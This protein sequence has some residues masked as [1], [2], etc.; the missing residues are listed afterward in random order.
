MRHSKDMAILIGGHAAQAFIL[1]ATTRIMTALLS[2]QE[3]GRFAII[4]TIIALILALSISSV[5]TYIQRRIIEWK[6]AGTVRFYI[7]RYIEFLFGMA[8][9]AAGLIVFLKHQAGIAVD[10]SDAWI[11]VIVVGLVF[12]SNVNLGYIVNLNIFKKRLWF[13]VCSNFTLLVG[14]LI[15][16]VLVSVFAPRAEY[17]I[18]GQIIGQ[19]ILGVIGAALFYRIVPPLKSGNTAGLLHP[20]FLSDV[21]RFVWPLS[22][23][24]M[25]IW[26]Q[27]QSYR[28]VMEYMHGMSVV[29]FFT[30]GFNLGSRLVEKV[31]NLLLNFYDPIFF[32]NIADSDRSQRVRVWNSF[33]GFFI[34]AMALFSI[35]VCFSGHF[36]ARIFFAPG[37]RPISA[38]VIFWGGAVMFILNIVAAY[39][40][41]GIADLKMTGLIAPYTLGACVTLAGVFIFSEW[42]PYQGVG[43][44]L[45]L[46]SLTMAVYLMIKMHKLL[47]VSFPLRR[48]LWAILAAVPMAAAILR[49]QRSI[50]AP[51]LGQAVGVLG[52]AGLYQLGVQAAL[53][54]RWIFKTDA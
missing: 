5:G 34:P 42:D 24:S 49:C 7:R 43:L 4:Y 10:I 27:S 3:M 15:A 32:T 8:V 14:L 23:S 38:G 47:P 33:A 18:L 11:V 16:V 21:L 53:A 50:P 9:F 52:L 13:T 20:A 6:R 12:I 36:L 17:W 29:G 48:T 40:K 19:F 2:P 54:R 26:I 35:Y 45:L 44:A 22:V 46:G 25:I 1:L 51:S 37:F 30:V 41:V 28:F 31:Y 39:K